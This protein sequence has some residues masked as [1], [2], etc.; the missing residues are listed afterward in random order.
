METER[1]LSPLS[2]LFE[3]RHELRQH[4]ALETALIERI[5]ELPEDD[6]CRSAREAMSLGAGYAYLC[7]ENE[8]SED[9][10]LHVFNAFFDLQPHNR[11]QDPYI[12]RENNE[13]TVKAALDW[14]GSDETPEIDPAVNQHTVES[15]VAFIEG[16]M[17][18]R[19]YFAGQQKRGLIESA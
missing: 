15:L 3:A 8:T 17:M 1:R 5:T 19:D 4:L 9:Q 7:S 13:K 10:W 18:T 14:L 11:Y 6:F 16:F 12:A 2:R